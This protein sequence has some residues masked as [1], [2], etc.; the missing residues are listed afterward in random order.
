[1][2]DALQ[3]RRLAGPARS[4]NR[5]DVTSLYREIDALEDLGATVGQLQVLDLKH[6]WSH[7]LSDD[8]S[9]STPVLS[10]SHSSPRSSGV[11]NASRFS[12]CFS[13]S[14]TKSDLTMPRARRS[15]PSLMA[16][17]S[18]VS[19]PWLSV[20]GKLKQ[21]ILESVGHEPC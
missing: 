1:M 18:P 3:E 16:G 20:A 13:R 15:A 6:F 8:S 7:V 11:S 4:N 12:K 17:M 21:W 5:N 14:L 10:S 2:V 9:G 19:F